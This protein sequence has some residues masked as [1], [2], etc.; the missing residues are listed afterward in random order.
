MKVIV[1]GAQ[2]I[3]TSLNRGW[4]PLSE[5]RGAA[6]DATLGGAGCVWGA[7]VAEF[8]IGIIW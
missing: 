2:K 7:E 6:L 4:V 1:A 3:G 8:C 5:T